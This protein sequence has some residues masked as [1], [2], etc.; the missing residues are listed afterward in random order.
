MRQFDFYEVVAV[1]APGMVLIIGVVFLFYPDQQQNCLS[2]AN[3]S[4]GSLGVGLIL[5]YVAG[6]LLQVVGNGIE[7]I[8]WKLWGG[9]P[10]DWLRSG[11]H[12]LV[13]I[14]QSDLIKTHISVML[15]SPSLEPQ[16]IKPKEWYSIARHI[17]AAVA[18][19]GRSARVDV[20]NGNYGLCRGL[21]AAF[22]VLIFWSFILDCNVGRAEVALVFLVFLALYRMHRFGE[23]YARELFIQFIVIKEGKSEG[24][25][26]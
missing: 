21:V 17:Y 18:A 12:D 20:F 10:T 4:L 24:G 16:S 9:M 2:I 23:R 3:L 15:K 13:S 7:S 8:W 1:I 26:K 25:P 11:K 22:S 5:A 19:E 6:Q 14:T